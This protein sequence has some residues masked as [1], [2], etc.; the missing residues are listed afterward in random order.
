MAPNL[1]F[2]C[3][4]LAVGC[5]RTKYEPSRPEGQMDESSRKERPEPGPECEPQGGG[6]LMPRLI[7]PVRPEARPASAS[8]LAPGQIPVDVMPLP[9]GGQAE[10]VG[11]GD[12]PSVDEVVRALHKVLQDEGARVAQ[13]PVSTEMARAVVE[14]VPAPAPAVRES[15]PLRDP[16]P[17]VAFASPP[18]PSVADV[19]KALHE[20]G[21]AVSDAGPAVPVVG[22]QQ[23]EIEAAGVQGRLPAGNAGAPER[24]PGPVVTEISWPEPSV[25]DVL[26][27][28]HAVRSAPAALLP[29][30]SAAD[31]PFPEPSVADVL[32]GLHAQSRD[33]APV[34][35]A[36]ARLPVAARIPTIETARPSAARLATPPAPSEPIEVPAPEVPAEA[37]T[38]EEPT[39]PPPPPAEPVPAAVPEPRDSEAGELQARIIPFVPR[40]ARSEPPPAEAV[41]HAY[42]KP[43]VPFFAR[44]DEGSRPWTP[45]PAQPP[46]P[47]GYRGTAVARAPYVVPSQ[48]PQ[49]DGR[50]VEQ[51]PAWWRGIAWGRVVRVTAKWL[52]VL[53]IAYATLVLTLVIAY[54]WIDPPMSSLML[55]QRLTGGSVTQRWVPL[56]RI[57]PNLQHAVILSED[58]QFCRHRGVDWGELKEAIEQS[59]DGP[60]RGGS[61]ISM[62]LVKNLFLWSSKSYIR[63]AIEIPLALLVERVW[64]KARVL[65]IY[66][67]IAEWGPGI[68]GAEAAAR[69]HFGKSAANLSVREASLLAVSLPNPFDRR[70]GRP[71]AGTQRLADNLQARMRRTASVAACGRAPKG[72]ASGAADRR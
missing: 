65:E 5:R 39:P 35:P 68:F 41:A 36:A 23:S 62:Q 18:E 67:N 10:E 8:A 20:A 30:Q 56:E 14:D 42:A 60:V 17:S 58:G 53:L 28:L 9:H 71:G 40:H 25:A 44:T 49:A 57:S 3:L 32:A 15:V 48:S 52:A 70:A 4:Y 59:M 34:Q 19:I 61:T 69:Y 16:V 11:E 13:A 50:A 12:H 64:P 27:D 38:A 26:A 47:D 1:P 72:T 6:A 55:S 37:R 29:V 43:V 54:R 21:D 66:L 33:H 2:G 22:V 63:K 45:P 24:P 7:A 46:P 51:A 31:V